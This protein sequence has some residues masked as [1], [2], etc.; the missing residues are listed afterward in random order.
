MKQV[1]ATLKYKLHTR[2]SFYVGQGEVLISTDF[3]RSLQRL[4]LFAV[5][6]N[7]SVI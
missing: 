7:S 5:I 6:I 3:F 4:N 2:K 1:S